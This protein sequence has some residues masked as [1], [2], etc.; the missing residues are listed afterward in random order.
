V[1][2]AGDGN[3]P[4]SAVFAPS[5]T[6]LGCSFD[7][8]GTGDPDGHI[9]TYAWAF[10][11]GGTSS[12]ASPTHTYSTAGTYP[13]KLTV[14]D[15]GGATDSVTHSVTVTAPNPPP[16]QPFAADTFARTVA[17]GWGRADTGGAWTTT[18]GAAFSVTPGAGVIRHVTKGSQGSASLNGVSSTDTDLTL[19]FNVDKANAGW[20]LTATGRRASS[21]NEYQARIALNTNNTVNAW[22]TKTLGGTQTS[23]VAERTVPGL[24]YTAGTTL[25]MRLQVTGTTPTTI[26]LKI[27]PATGTEPATW[28]ATTTDTTPALQNPGSLALVSY[29]S[30]AST[31]APVTAHITDLTASHT[32]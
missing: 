23:M 17:S 21:G 11:D 2:N 1:W 7:S 19:G 30:S 20:Y 28:F 27:W 13:V 3:Q 4:P 8:T 26:R 24:T 9:A 15:D 12:A 31:T 18:S 22:L 25:R 32:S 5:C 16:N 10:G 14:T 6:D 29:L